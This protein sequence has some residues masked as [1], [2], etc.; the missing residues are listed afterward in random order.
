MIN[1]PIFLADACTKQTLLPDL[2]RGLRTG[3]N[4]EVEINSIYDVR[5]LIANGIEIALTIAVFVAVGF[6]IYG[7]FRYIISSGDPSGVK[8]AKET[9]VNAII[10]LVLAMLSFGIVRFITGS[11]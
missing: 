8:K 7:G 2:W 4:C 9:I 6:I 5:N 10:G 11:F 3:G 1:L